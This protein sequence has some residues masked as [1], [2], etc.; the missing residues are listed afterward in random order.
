MKRIG[1]SLAA[2]AAALVALV[3]IVPSLAPE[4]ALREVL[5][6]QLVALTGRPVR[7]DGPVRLS[8]APLPTLLVEKVTIPGPDGM[9]PLLVTDKLQGELNL[10]PLL[11]GRLD[12]SSLMLKRAR[13][14]LTTTKTNGHSWDFKTGVLAD[15]A[16]G[17]FETAMP[18]SALRLVDSTIQYADAGGQLTTVSVEDAT[19]A[20][21]GLTDAMS[22]A[23]IINWRDR[24]AE[25]SVAIIEPAS[26]ISGGKSDMRARIKGEM[27]N[28]T[29]SGTVD[30]DGRLEGQVTAS[31][32]SLRETLRWLGLPL[33]DGHSLA[34][35]EVQS[36][37]TV[38]P[39]GISLDD[40][41]LSL[42]G[43]EAE[44]SLVIQLAG[45]RPKV[46]G[47]LAADT[48][49]LSAY[50][51][52]VQLSRGMPRQ[53]RDDRINIKSLMVSDLDVRI[54]AGETVID[55]IRL[56]RTAA[57][58]S[59]HDGLFEFALG[60]AAAYGGSLKGN[61]TLKS[62]GSGVE[63][64]AGGNFDSVEMGKSLAD[65]FGFHH[66]EGTGE[67]SVEISGTGASVAELS[68]SLEGQADIKVNNGALIGIDLA[69]LMQKIEKRPLSARFESGYGGR[70]TF[71]TAQASLKI[72]AGLAKTTDCRMDNGSLSVTLAGQSNIAQRSLDMAGMANWS[73]GDGARPF[74]L[75]FR[76]F[77]GWEVP[78]VEPDTEALIRRSGAAAPLLRSFAKPGQDVTQD[79]VTSVPASSA[80]AQ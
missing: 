29:T 47:T 41:Q 65:F 20:W 76:V 1:L 18:I 55:K 8:W 54:S 10:T 39:T 59:S 36:P 28:L 32:A 17:H 30:G 16:N 73:D 24:N 57:T 9:P 51:S 31:G 78:V 50:S 13:I 14:G 62:T 25:I 69:D 15:A 42:D 63:F 7:I 21:S 27:L 75:P 22:V 38:D 4:S 53:W 6:R 64:T 2:I 67:G 71:D 11:I 46:S 33:P 79:S 43:N 49:D 74:H 48:I 44:G 12:V 5:T 61:V 52:E 72:T 26:L 23:G 58:I 60:E 70:T 77:G 35:F 45:E 56:G 34:A 19:L 66:L 3:L 40:V 37:V 68:R 80:Q